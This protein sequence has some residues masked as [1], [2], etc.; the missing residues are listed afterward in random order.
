MLLQTNSAT[1]SYPELNPSLSHRR[2]RSLLCDKWTPGKCVPAGTHIHT[3]THAVTHTL[4]HIIHTQWQ[5]T[6]SEQ[7]MEWSLR[8]RPHL[9]FTCCSDSVVSVAT[10]C[11]CVCVCTC[12]IFCQ[13]RLSSLLSLLGAYLTSPHTPTTLRTQ[14]RTGTGTHTNSR[15]TQVDVRGVTMWMRH[16]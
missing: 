3:Q 2:K 15:H 7:S 9:Q 10:A 6:G 16:G 12:V 13:F 14:I 8:H 1:H 11:M 4:P 5:A